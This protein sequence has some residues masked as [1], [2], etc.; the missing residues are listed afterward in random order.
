MVDSD[1]PELSGK[2][3]PESEL[4]AED[5]PEQNVAEDISEEVQP[6]QDEAEQESNGGSSSSLA[7]PGNETLGVAL[8]G[9]PDASTIVKVFLLQEQQILPCWMRPL[10]AKKSVGKP[11]M[12]S[13][14]GS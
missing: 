9:E 12:M 11:M 7:V 8:S 4:M 5:L 13:G 2:G 10:R 3:E 6:E 1:I 14:K